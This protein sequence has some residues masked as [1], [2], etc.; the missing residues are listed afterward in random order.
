MEKRSHYKIYKSP[1]SG[2]YAYKTYKIYG[3]GKLWTNF[4]SMLNPFFDHFLDH[5]F[6]DFFDQFLNMKKV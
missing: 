4:G 6:D 5:F 2:S 1:H 3:G